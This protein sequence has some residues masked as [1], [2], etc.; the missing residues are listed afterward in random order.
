VRSDPDFP[1]STKNLF[2]KTLF[3]ITLLT[4]LLSNAWAQTN[5][6]V[7]NLKGTITDNSTGKPLAFATLVLQNIK[8]G[9]P[10]KNF[11]SKDDGSFEISVN[12]SL[13]YQLVIAFTGYE[14]KSVQI[15]KGQSADLGSISLKPADKQMK[16]VSVVAVRPLIKRDLDGITYD[17][18]ADPETQSLSALD[19]M[20]KVPLLSVDGSDNIR[21]KGKSNYKIL[22]NGKESALMV[23]NP[24]DVLRSMPATNIERIE[25]ITTP[26]AKYD[27]EGLAGI[28]NIITKKKLDEGYNIG[29]NGRLNTIWG[30]GINLNGTYKKGKFGFSGYLGYNV[31]HSQTNAIGGQQNFFS[32]NSSLVQNGTNTAA[33]HNTYGDAELSYEIDSLNLLTGSFEF[34]KGNYSQDGNQLS[35]SFD[36]NQTLL[37]AYRILSG[38][39]NGFAGIDASLNYQLGFKKDKNRLLTI[40][41]KYSYS[42]N[43][44]NLSNTITDTFNYNLPNYKQ[45]NESGSKEHTIQVDYVHPFKVINLEAGAKSILRNNFSN[46]E[47]SNY[48]ETTKDYEIN[49]TQTNDFNYDQDIYSVYNSYSAKWKKLNAKAGLRLEHTTVRADFISSSGTVN[50][51]YNNL[52][53]SLSVQWNL[54]NSNISLGYTDRISRPGIAQLNPFV[55]YSNPN[56]INTGNPNLQAEVNHNFELNYSLF[57]KNSLTAGLSYSFSNNA[58]QTV[59]RLQS[60]NSGGVTD[61]VTVTTYENLGTNKTLG[62]N[63]NWTFTSVKNLS[64]SLNTQLSHVWLKGT[65]NGQFFRNDGYTGNAFLN[66]GFKF[67]KGFRVG[68]DAGYFSGDVNL[69][70]QTSPFIFNS[71]TISKTFLNKRLT[72]TAVMNNPYNRFYTF[73]S[74]TVTPDFYQSTYNDIFYRSFALR[75]NFKF[76]KLNSD[77]K[78]NQRGINN[79]DKKAGKS[80]GGTP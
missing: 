55:D 77:I 65:Y 57:S 25:V 8:S 26:P 45:Y 31:R 21:L 34:Y 46:F 49:P 64:I 40:S 5:V 30:P 44:Q 60:I 28:I 14:N 15:V 79:D 75:F 19:M 76:G 33:A 74:T 71:Y 41:Y 66:T 17:V 59:T 24:S 11:L 16:E 43:T 80:S 13:D 2:V 70:G 12:D 1:A 47:T 6:S 69:Q 54:T 62:L 38:A 29:V 68:F 67:G 48:D 39:S 27:A 3:L 51:D 36:G 35:N 9:K 73:K 72:L 52:V 58:I 32:D 42:P 23:K 22:I 78:K 18:S 63:L 4:C 56:F 7:I 50:Q 61:S 37:Q 10:V 53:P 20:R